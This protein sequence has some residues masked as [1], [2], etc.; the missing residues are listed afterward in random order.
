MKLIVIDTETSDL[1]PAKGAHL[2]ELSFIELVQIESKWE[3]S[4]IYESYIQY[5]GPISPHARA[6]HHIRDDQLTPENGAVT[7]TEAI[8]ALSNRVQADS[9]LVAHNVDFDAKFLPE[10]ANPW[11]CTLRSARH[12]W[13]NAPGYSNQVLKY[14]LGLAVSIPNRYPHQALY[15]VTTTA[16]ILKE[17]LKMHSPESLIKMCNQPVRV[18]SLNFGKHR[19]VPLENVPRDYLSWLRQQSNLDPDVKHTIDAMLK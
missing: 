1:D 4:Y 12:I 7:R 15:D 10:L 16:A 11:L 5:S 2:L 18:K 14:W 8:M 6:V 17:M 9:I 13:P 3:S 19:G